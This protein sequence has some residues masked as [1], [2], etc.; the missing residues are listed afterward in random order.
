[1]PAMS[2]S[3]FSLKQVVLWTGMLAAVL[4]E[5]VKVRIDFVYEE[6]DDTYRDRITKNI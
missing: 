1:M 4:E 3:S 5:M 2:A 6:S